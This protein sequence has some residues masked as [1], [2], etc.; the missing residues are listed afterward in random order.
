MLAG[1]DRREKRE[2]QLVKGLRPQAWLKTGRCAGQFVAWH[3]A[4]RMYPEL[5]RW[6]V[7]YLLL[8]VPFLGSE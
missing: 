5:L 1:T 2:A 7:R 6:I 4:R 8:Y 3:R